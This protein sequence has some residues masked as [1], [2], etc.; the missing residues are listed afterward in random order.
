MF[1]PGRQLQLPRCRLRQLARQPTGQCRKLVR[2]T[3]C[4]LFII[5][6]VVSAGGFALADATGELKQAG[7]L[8]KAGRVEG[9]YRLGRAY[10]FGREVDKDLFEAARQ[11][12]LAAEQDHVEAQFSLALILAGAVPNSPRSPQE[13]FKW[14]SKAAHQGHARSTYFLALSYQT[15]AGVEASSEKAFQWY[16]R[17][18]KAGSGE[19]MHA[20]ARMYTTGVG[21]RSNLANAYAWNEVAGASG[22]EPA[23]QYRTTLEGMMNTADVSRGKRLVGGLM[24]KYARPPDS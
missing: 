7:Q 22:Y 2:E 21:I 18:A 4:V 16:R 1:L 15:G 10:E 5:A 20:M 12:Q 8:A 9:Y 19:A 3:L 17:A 23:S 14:F 13:S 24:K 11:Y 6:T